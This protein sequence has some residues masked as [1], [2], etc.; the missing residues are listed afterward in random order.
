METATAPNVG[1]SARS[2]VAAECQITQLTSAVG[3]TYP[4]GLRYPGRRGCSHG[5][6]GIDVVAQPERKF[7]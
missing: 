6:A 3:L 5:S 1:E 4:M 2:D 7:R